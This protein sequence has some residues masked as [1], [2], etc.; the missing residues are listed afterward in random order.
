RRDVLGTVKGQRQTKLKALEGPEGLLCA[1]LRQVVDDVKHARPATR[2]TS[3]APTV[4]Q[5]LSAIEWLLSGEEISELADL[6]QL[7]DTWL[8]G[9]LLRTAGLAQGT[10]RVGQRRRP[11]PKHMHKETRP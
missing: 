6:L 9:E 1:V 4:A 10:P 3:A 11:R 5:Q 2:P 8:R 7:D